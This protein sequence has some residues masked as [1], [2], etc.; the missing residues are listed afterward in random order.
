MIKFTEISESVERKPVYPERRVWLPHLTTAQ[1]GSAEHLKWMDENRWMVNYDVFMDN[2]PQAL[3]LA[4]QL[5]KAF[6]EN[7]QHVDI[8][9][10]LTYLRK[11]RVKEHAEL[12]PIERWTRCAFQLVEYAG[13]PNVHRSIRKRLS[14]YS[15]K[16]LEAMCGHMSYFPEVPRRKVTALDYCQVSLKRYPFPKRRRIECDLNQITDGAQLH[17][18]K[19]SEFDTISI[20]FGFK[21]PKDIVSLVN[22]FRRI[23]KPGGVLSFVEN[24]SHGY[25]DLC[26]RKFDRNIVE[27]LKGAGYSR[28]CCDT[29][30]PPEWDNKRGRFY[31]VEAIK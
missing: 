21:Y 2:K 31:H 18:F 25:E 13:G 27:I 20:C 29:F 14:K 16:V 28:Y 24:P 12:D 17:F 7:P 23:L 8:P 5:D 22:E 9:K 26:Q 1:Q 30:A 11:L 15:G 19:E 6:K 10:I 4:Q 3:Q